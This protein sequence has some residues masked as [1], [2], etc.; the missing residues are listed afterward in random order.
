[1]G[2]EGGLP[3]EYKSGPG[4]IVSTWR[5]VLLIL[6]H[7]EIT[8]AALDVTERAG[9]SLDRE[10][11]RNQVSVSITTR[12]VPLPSDE[13]R[14]HA[15]RLLRERAD[16]VKLTITVVEGDGFWVSTGRM[17]MTALVALSGSKMKPI[18]ARSVEEAVPL[19]EPFVT[20]RAAPADIQ[21]A[22]VAFRG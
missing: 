21:R 15:A 20:P 6:W 10:Y 22:L 12:G 13:V 19:V 9:R 11:P 7:G 4:Y 18:I 5:N 3:T 16:A 17:V 14:K 8:S 2:T 1:M